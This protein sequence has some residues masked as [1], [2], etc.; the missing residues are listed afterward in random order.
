MKIKQKP[1]NEKICIFFLQNKKDK[2]KIQKKVI[3]EK[4]FDTT[5]KYAPLLLVQLFF[6][7]FIIL[8]IL[9]LTF[10]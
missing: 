3:F 1:S 10:L 4:F 9:L 6:R 8:N 5:K 2:I 7:Y